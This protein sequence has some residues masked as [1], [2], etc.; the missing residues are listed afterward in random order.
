MTYQNERLIIKFLM[1]T[2]EMVSWNTQDTNKKT[3]SCYNLQA[4]HVFL[5]RLRSGN[6]RLNTHLFN[7]VKIGQSQ[8]CP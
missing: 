7:T 6:N 2:E 8:M 4:D 1:H 5:L 3:D